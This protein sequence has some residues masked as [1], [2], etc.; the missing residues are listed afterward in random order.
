MIFLNIY[1]VI[2]ADVV[3]SRESDILKNEEYSN[4][5]VFLDER[6]N[7]LNLKLE[8]SKL[9]ILTRVSASRGDEIQVVCKK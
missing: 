5:K 2:T 4:V 9:G 6:I 1:A 3:D 8:I 7:E